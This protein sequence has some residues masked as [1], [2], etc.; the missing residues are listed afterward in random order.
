MRRSS[1]LIPLLV[2]FAF[3]LGGCQT[4]TDNTPANTPATTTADAT[5]PT[6]K[7]G[8]A[9]WEA[10]MG[11][12]GEY[13][14]A[15]SYEAVIEKFGPVEPYVSIERAEL[16]HIA[17]LTRQLR[18]LG[19]DVPDNPYTGTITAP[20]DLTTAA[21]AWADGEIANVAMYDRLIAQSGSDQM[22]VR[23]LTNLRRASQESHLPLFGAA[24]ANGGTLS[25]EDMR[26][27]GR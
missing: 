3:T 22:V 25:P 8:A 14:A 17:A 7:V 13:A 27:M 10:L 4:G 21:Q 9:V 1:F 6:D 20:K 12:D 15:S 24:A 19:V 16:R 5:A 11:P 26:G 18:R 2:L 23:V